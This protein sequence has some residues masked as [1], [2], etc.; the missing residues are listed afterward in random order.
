M[1]LS[2]EGNVGEEGESQSQRKS[3]RGERVEKKRRR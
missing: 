1:P 3:A 2:T